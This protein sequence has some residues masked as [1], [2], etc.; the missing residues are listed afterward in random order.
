LAEELANVRALPS[1][2][3]DHARILGG[4]ISHLLDQ[5]ID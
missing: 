3:T 1:S 4:T 5:A 2:E